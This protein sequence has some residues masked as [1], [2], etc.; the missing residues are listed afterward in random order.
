VKLEYVLTIAKLLMKGAG[1]DF[2]NA[3]SSSIGT[4]INKSQQAASKIIIGLENRNLIERIKVGHGYKIRVTESGVVA[5]REVSNMLISAVNYSK[6][7]ITIEGTV[8]SG[9]G[10]GGYYMSLEGYRKRF[11]NRL[12]YIP[13]PGTLNLKLSGNLSIKN[14]ERIDQL[15]YI[16]I[17][18]FSD[19]KRSYG[20]VKCYAVLIN[21]N[22]NIQAHVLVL[23]RTHHDNTV[24]EV[25]SPNYLK[26]ALGL[27]NGDDVRITLVN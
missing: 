7:K 4:E 3:T 6:I 26:E 5:V 17:N 25:I 13:Y 8:V 24:I 19:S 11:E 23:E 10:E 9:M 20:W 12:G 15:P 22:H 16:L 27:R 2:I 1:E 14:R 18:G 21:G